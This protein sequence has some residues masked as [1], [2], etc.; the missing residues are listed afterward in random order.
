MGIFQSC[1]KEFLLKKIKFHPS[2][3]NKKNVT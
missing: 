1:F 2:L 3:E